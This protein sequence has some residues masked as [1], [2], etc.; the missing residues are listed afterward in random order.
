MIQTRRGVFE[1][2]SSSTHSVTIVEDSDYEKWKNGELF[3]IINE[4]KF[5][6][7]WEVKRIKQEKYGALVMDLY[8][9]GETK[10]LIDAIQNKEL[11]QY[12]EEN[13]DKYDL[14]VSY[15]EFFDYDFCNLELDEESYTTK[16][17]EKIYIICRY[18]YDC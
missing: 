5:V 2:N 14:P 1:T 9:D 16:G 11:E 3:Y 13:Y 18:G 4:D 12:L 7:K 8:E 17:G 15:D 6:D 10:G